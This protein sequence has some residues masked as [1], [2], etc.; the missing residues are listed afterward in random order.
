[1]VSVAMAT[2]N[3]E[4]YICEQVNSVLKQTYSDFELVIC[5]DCSKDSTVQILREYEKKDSRIKIFINE[6][7]MGF[8]KNFE[9][10][11]SFCSGDYIAFCDQDDIWESKHLEILL[12]EI[13]D[14]KVICGNELL[15]DTETKEKRIKIPYK[16]NVF[17]TDS[18]NLIWTFSYT[19]NFFAGNAMLVERKFLVERNILP[20]PNGISHDSWIALC[21]C[22]FSKM[23]FTEKVVTNR[24]LHH[25]NTTGL[26]INDK[27]FYHRVLNRLFGRKKR[28]LIYK[29][30]VFSLRKLIERL[31]I[32][33]SVRKII[34]TSVK[35]AE[36]K[37]SCFCSVKRFKGLICLWKNYEK[38]FFWERKKSVLKIF[39]Y[40]F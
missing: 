30:I 29:N 20:I 10:L 1:M 34:T 40:L 25:D 35:I 39:I 13:G 14:A 21:A 28:K 33:E 15:F 4:K 12:N 27:K 16:Q 24:R 22:C 37:A 19:N 31:E 18:K 38:I 32:A 23:Q 36:G 17:P 9:K 2:Y 7:N 11:I 26:T 8:A 5:D 3:G 6:Q